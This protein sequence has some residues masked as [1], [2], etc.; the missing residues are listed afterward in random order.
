MVFIPYLGTKL[1]FYY[2]YLFFNKEKDQIGYWVLKSI[3]GVL[4]AIHLIGSLLVELLCGSVN[5][6]RSTLSRFYS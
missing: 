1:V 5:V 6:V 2:F 4:E 3:S